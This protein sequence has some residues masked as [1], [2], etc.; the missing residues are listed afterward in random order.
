MRQPCGSLRSTR[1]SPPCSSTIQR[2]IARPRPAPPSRRRA[3]RVGAVE[4]L[5]HARRLGVGD[6]G[7]FVDHFEA[8]R[9]RAPRRRARAPSPLRRRVPHRVLD[10]VRDH[11]VQPLGVGFE[12]EV[13]RHDLDRRS[14]RRRRAAATRGSRARA[15]ARRRTGAG[16]AAACPT[17]GGR[18]RA[19]AARAGRAVRPGRASCA[20]SRGRAADAVDE[21]LEHGLQRG[22]RRAQLVAHVGDEV[23]AQPIGLGELG[24]HLVERAGERADLVV[25]GGGDAL[26]EV[27]ARHRLGGRDHLAQRRGDAAREDPH[28]RERDET[29]RARR[30]TDGHMPTLHADA[31]HD[32][33]DRD[34]GEDDDAELELQRRQRIERPLGRARAL[35]VHAT[36]AP[37]PRSRR[38]ARC[39]RRRRRAC[40]GSSECASRRCAHPTA[41]RSPTPAR[42]TPRGST[43]RPGRAA[44]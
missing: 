12:P 25:R 10:E 21:V 32:D 42:A 44:R 15:S 1:M 4:A 26:R 34:R 39:A 43:T 22:D 36:R 16:R 33:R 19:A 6:A 9:R 5:E 11:L 18:G 24:R 3:G 35:H 30:A 14:A 37:R 40:G 13:A 7:A 17:R 31:E 20:A 38:R 27:A 41:R 8:A 2:A 29:R 23:A 28:D